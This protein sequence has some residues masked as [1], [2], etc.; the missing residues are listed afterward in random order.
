MI[1]VM[2]M[3][4]GTIGPALMLPR[5]LSDVAACVIV[6]FSGRRHVSPVTPPSPCRRRLNGL[7]RLF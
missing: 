2:G 5:I 1:G 3:V 4:V 7:T 6:V